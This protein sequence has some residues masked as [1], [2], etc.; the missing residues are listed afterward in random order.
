MTD[1]GPPDEATPEVSP[2]TRGLALFIQE[3]VTQLRNRGLDKDDTHDHD[4]L[5]FL[6]NWH[7]AHPR[8]LFH[9]PVL[10]PVDKVVW[11]IIRHHADLNGAAAFPTYQAIARYANVK[12]SATVAR[13]IMIL[14]ITR[15]MSLCARVRD[16]QGRYKGNVYALHDEPITLG[17]VRHL[18]P[19]YLQFLQQMQDYHHDRVRQVARSVLATIEEG[20]TDGRDITRERSL[21]HQIERRLSA[22]RTASGESAGG[23][24]SVSSHQ[25]KVLQSES[26][27][28]IQNLN[29]ETRPQ[30]LKVDEHRV[31][32]LNS[33]QEIKKKQ[34]DSAGLQNLNTG[35]VCSSSFNKNTTT[36]YT[37]QSQNL[38]GHPHEPVPDH[39]HFPTQLSPDEIILA[40]MHL[41][42]IP[43]AHRQDVLDELQGRLHNTQAGGEPIRNPIGYLAQLCHAV[44]ADT[45][46]FTSLGL[47]VR[48]ARM[49]RANLT[50]EMARREEAFTKEIQLSPP[51]GPLAQR[52]ERIRQG[53]KRDDASQGVHR[54]PPGIAPEGKAGVSS[55]SQTGGARCTP[56]NQSGTRHQAPHQI[57]E[58][59]APCT[60]LAI[61]TNNAE[62]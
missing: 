22:L 4:G 45:F 33:D 61:E 10:E 30:K 26:K 12:S 36:T 48:E 8:L 43:N 50:Q 18:D 39:L 59:G 19:D 60:P 51:S 42:G 38:T 56:Q 49:R 21:P 58:G 27:D 5:L 7:D 9:D 28:H 15:W 13:A 46:Q 20:T 53:R 32:I 24:Y 34:Q 25:L 52:V 40:R 1:I 35:T 29:T 3:A 54:A 6:G 57:P 62:T 16:H 17:D 2:R 41:Q 14:R 23:F 44:R 47:K 55:D 11:V 37:G 31:Q